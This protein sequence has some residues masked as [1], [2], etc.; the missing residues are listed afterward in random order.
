MKPTQTLL[1]LLF[2]FFFL[3]S[4]RSSETIFE[5]QPSEIAE[6]T[7]EPSTGIPVAYEIIDTE[8]LSHKAMVQRPLSSYTWHELTRLPM[9]KK[10]AYRVLVSPDIKANQIKPTIEKAISVITSEDP[11]IDEIILWLYSDKELV[12]G[13]YDVAMATWAPGGILGNV[14]ANIAQSNDRTG[15]ELSIEVTHNLEEYL[16]QRGR[17]DERFGFTE[18]QRRQI[19]KEI[20]AA[21]DRATAAAERIY[22]MDVFDPNYKPENI[23]KHFEKS[24]EFSETYRAK[25]REKYGIS[26]EIQKQISVEGLTERWPMETK[27]RC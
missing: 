15:Y 12:R 25:V 19:F 1:L 17:S 6:V 3:I 5:Q 18:E 21:E 26:E 23:G 24:D 16:E 27:G 4:C 7:Q 20:V 2:P 13:S 22:P 9:D 11:D 8:D 14:D 10:I